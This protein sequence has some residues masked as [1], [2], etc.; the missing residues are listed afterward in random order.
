M[1]CPTDNDSKGM[2]IVLSF[3]LSKLIQ[4]LEIRQGRILQSCDFKNFE[5]GNTRDIKSKIKK[6]KNLNPLMKL[7]NLKNS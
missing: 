7:D 5:K 3:V 2:N 6:S 1:T 4:I